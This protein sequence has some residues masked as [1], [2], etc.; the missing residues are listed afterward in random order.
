[1]ARPGRA[2]ASVPSSC[3]EGG[4]HVCQADSAKRP[5][6]AVAVS[7]SL[8]PAVWAAGAARLLAVRTAAASSR[9]ARSA[10]PTVVTVSGTP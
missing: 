9:W 4:A 10:E 6:T 1:M 3:R 7:V 2:V 8:A 5:V